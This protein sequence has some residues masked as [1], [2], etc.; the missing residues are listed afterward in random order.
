MK[1]GLD[2]AADRLRESGSLFLE[3]FQ[4]GSLSVELY[5]PDKVDRQQ[6]H[7]RDEIYVVARGSGRFFHDGAWMDFTAGDVLFVPAGNEHYFQDFT[8]DFT[9]WVFFYGP[10]G[11]ETST[12]SKD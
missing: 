2:K 12:D 5:K 7:S 10:E 9:T 8:D 11:G 4:H 6:P 1:I 3:M